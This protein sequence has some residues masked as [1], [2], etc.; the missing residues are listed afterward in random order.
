MSVSDDR[1][2]KALRYLA[3]TDERAA[4]LKA[5]VERQEYKVKAM[6]A[7][8]FKLSDG[9]VADRNAAAET[10]DDV[11]KA[12]ADHVKAIAA[13]MSVSN[14]RATETLIVD[15]WRTCAANR[16]HGNV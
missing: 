1:M 5:D 13:Y 6:K 9:T 16:R 7:A 11:I 3:E 2:E 14:K 15:V 4:E 12:Q 8:V 10:A